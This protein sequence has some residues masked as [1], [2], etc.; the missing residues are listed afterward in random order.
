[1]RSM[2]HYWS[3]RPYIEVHMHHVNLPLVYRIKKIITLHK[4]LMLSKGAKRWILD[5]I[6]RIS[7]YIWQMTIARSKEIN[8]DDIFILNLFKNI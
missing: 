7:K 1:M 3:V 2:I 6:T 5:D 4:R 8:K